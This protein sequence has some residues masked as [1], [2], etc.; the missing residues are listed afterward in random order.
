M[1]LVDRFGIDRGPTRH[2]G[3]IEWAA[4]TGQVINDTHNRLLAMLVGVP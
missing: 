2:V 4:V 3:Q 1:L